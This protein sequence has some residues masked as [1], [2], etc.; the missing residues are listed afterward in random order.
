M[1]QTSF[2]EKHTVHLITLGCPKNYV[3]SEF[4][5]RQLKENGYP[6]IHNP[7]TPSGIVLLN[8][9][10]FIQ[11]ARQESI[12]A[13]LELIELKKQGNIEKIILFGCLVQR[14][15]NELK[16]ELPE[17]DAFF[18][19]DREVEILRYVNALYHENLKHERVLSTPPHYAY[20]KIAEGCDRHCAFCAIPDIRGKYKSKPSEDII[21]EARRLAEKNVKEIILI[22]QDTTYYGIDLNK[23]AQ[24]PDLVETM[25]NSINIPWLRLHYL[26]PASFP[27]ALLDV[28]SS[29]SKICKYIDIPIQHISHNMLSVMRRGIGKEQTIQLLHTIRERVPGVHIRTTLITGH[30]GE[31]EKDF[32]ELLDFVKQFRF[33]RLGVFIYSHEEGTYSAEQYSDNIPESV[34]QSRMEAIM[35]AQQQISLE[36]NQEKTGKTFRVIIDREEEDYYIART[37]FDAPE[38]DNEVLIE[39][40]KPLTTGKFYNVK[41]KEAEVYDLF[42][43]AEN[44]D[45]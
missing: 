33:D 19:I 25:V 7:E 12:D 26:Y 10:G 3:D 6:I 36:K 29:Y 4:L 38:I 43:E 16:A 31:T 42:G 21:L 23:Q 2:P 34:K 20:L 24:L 18:G 15:V 8:T 32:I 17:V 11:D 41:I 37:E 45:K 27:P 28:V 40:N 22:A 14:Y 1:S 44:T 35:E 30:P 13:I 39:K 5:A 9:C